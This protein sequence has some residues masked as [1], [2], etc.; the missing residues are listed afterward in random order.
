MI[1]HV[2]IT[3]PSGACQ[4]SKMPAKP[5]SWPDFMRMRIGTFL[6]PSFFHSKNPSAGMM[7]RFF[8]K[9]FLK[10]GFSIRLSERALIKGFI[11]AKSFTQKGISPHLTR[12]TL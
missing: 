1:E 10:D 12:Q 3:E 6:P 11:F 4:S 2:R 9:A 5:K 8:L 7:H